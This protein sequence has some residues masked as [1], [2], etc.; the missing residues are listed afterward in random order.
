MGTE[1]SYF[2]R[3][4][5]A[6]H[7]AWHHVHHMCLTSDNRQVR[8]FWKGQNGWRTCTRIR[9]GSTKMQ[10]S[11]LY[12]F[13]YFWKGPSTRTHGYIAPVFVTALLKVCQISSRIECKSPWNCSTRYATTSGS[14]TPPSSC[15]STRRI[16][17]RR[18]SSDLHSPSVFR[19]TLVSSTALLRRN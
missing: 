10:K 8:P 18:R 7:V 17:S 6:I 11:V 5:C 1:N 9:P 4:T 15:S 2:S 16:S 3:N 19:S 12:T 13:E 14:A